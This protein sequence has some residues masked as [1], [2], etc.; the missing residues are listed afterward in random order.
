MSAAPVCEVTLL[1]KSPSFRI[2]NIAM[3]GE[4]AEC[5]Q[6]AQGKMGSAVYPYVPPPPPLYPY[7]RPGW[8]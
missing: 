6:L 1:A 3:R 7:Y 8:R 2:E 4:A 5:S